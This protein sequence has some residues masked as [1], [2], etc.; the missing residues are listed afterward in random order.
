MNNDREELLKQL[1]A[2]DFVAVDLHLFLD[3]HPNDCQAVNTLNQVLS[4]ADRFRAEYERRF[5]PLY[6]FRSTSSCPWQWPED[7]W[8]WEACANFE[9]GRADERC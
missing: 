1:M 2:L 4:E 6:S 5:G 9:L 8:P 7:P 3:T